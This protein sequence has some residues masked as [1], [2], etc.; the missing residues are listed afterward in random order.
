[1]NREED[2]DLQDPNKPSAKFEA[3][4]SRHRWDGIVGELIQGKADMSFAPLSVTE[5]R[6]SAI[7]FTQPYHYGS[8][9]MCS[10]PRPNSDIPLLAFLLPFSFELWIAIFTSLNITAIAVALYEWF[11]PFGLN[12]WGRQRSKN[13]SISSGNLHL[14]QY[15]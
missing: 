13:F 7:D 6:V 4:E 14:F 15:F 10:A 11:S 3:Y 9:S 1:M 8:V 2:L 5:A 12:P